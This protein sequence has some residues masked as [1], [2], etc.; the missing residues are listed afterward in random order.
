MKQKTVITCVEEE[1]AS[2]VGEYIMFPQ[3]KTLYVDR[4]SG[5]VP[6]TKEERAVFTPK[7]IDDVFAHYRPSKEAL[8]MYSEDGDM[9]YEDFIFGKIEDFDDD[10]I[11]AQSETMTSSSDKIDTYH[12]IIRHLERNRDLKRVLGDEE[13]KKALIDALKA[14]RSELN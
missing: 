7:T 4:L 1:K 5:Y 14:M 6:D 11:I 10:N 3:N 13:A 2:G 12:D 9:R 8:S